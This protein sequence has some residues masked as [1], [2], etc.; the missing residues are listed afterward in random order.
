MAMVLPMTAG[1]GEAARPPGI[2][3]HSDG[4]RTEGFVIS[5]REFPAENR[6]ETE[7]GEISPGDELH[8]HRLQVR[9]AFDSAVHS[10]KQHAHL[11]AGFGEDMILQRELFVKAI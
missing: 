8:I 11:R 6:L 3:K 7:H 1:S 4:V 9:A 5:F 2:A 10:A